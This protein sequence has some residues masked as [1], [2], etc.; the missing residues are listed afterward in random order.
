MF[1]S[2]P[3]ANFSGIIIAI[4][5]GG[6]A[7]W[8]AYISN[9]NRKSTKVIRDVLDNSSVK[10]LDQVIKIL[11]DQVEFLSNQVRVLRE[12]NAKLRENL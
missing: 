5:G 3:I 4:I 9:K 8:A 1:S 12:E 7:V 10:S 6:F 2:G 11:Q